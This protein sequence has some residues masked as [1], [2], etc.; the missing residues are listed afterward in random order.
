MN[1]RNAILATSALLA[2]APRGVFAQSSTTPEIRKATL[3]YIALTD[4]APL[5]R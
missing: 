3:G 2:A 1:R 5:I 4:S